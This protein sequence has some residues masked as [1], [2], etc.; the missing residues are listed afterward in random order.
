VD[1]IVIAARVVLALQTIVS[2]ENSPF[3]PAVITVGTIHGGTKNNVIPDEV[4]LQ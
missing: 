2:R 3:D 1:P 4:K